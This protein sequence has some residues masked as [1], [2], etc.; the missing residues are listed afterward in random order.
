MLNHI[1]KLSGYFIIIFILFFF[2]NGLMVSA[3]NQE[4]S[5]FAIR[6]LNSEIRDQNSYLKIENIGKHWG[7]GFFVNFKNELYVVTARHIADQKCDLIGVV[8][9]KNNETGE[10]EKYKLFLPKNDWVYHPNNGN[11]QT[12]PVDVAVMRVDR[13]KGYEIIALDSDSDFLNINY[14][15]ELPYKDFSE[16]LYLCISYNW[17]SDYKIKELMSWDPTRPVPAFIT[18]EP[19]KKILQQKYLKNK[20]KC[21]TFKKFFED[22]VLFLK[23]NMYPGNSGS[24]VIDMNPFENPKKKLLGIHIASEKDRVENNFIP[25][26]LVAI[27]P[28]YR[29]IETLEFA[30]EKDRKGDSTPWSPLKF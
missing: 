18:N 12:C 5:S 2:E 11:I 22:E 21:Q 9:V 16:G 23:G 17:L 14:I 30:K 24:P 7:T 10:I 13:L 3:N 27:E 26:Q 25:L 29:I 1:K 6:I 4:E 19:K 28:S 8:R 15:E 20:I